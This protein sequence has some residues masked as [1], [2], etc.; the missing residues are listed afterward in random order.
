MIAV[1]IPLNSD[2]ITFKIEQMQANGEVLPAGNLDSLR[3]QPLPGFLIKITIK[4]L[5]VMHSVGKPAGRL[6][7]GVT[8]IGNAGASSP[9][10][11]YINIVCCA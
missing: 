2:S 3:P 11:G 7:P 8:C 9:V 6:K 1:A 4:N 10:I 5:P